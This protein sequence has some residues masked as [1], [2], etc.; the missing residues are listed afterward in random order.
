MK[1][2]WK[3][4]FKTVFAACIRNDVTPV[5][6]TRGATVDVAVKLA[7]QSEKSFRVLQ[8]NSKKTVTTVQ[9]GVLKRRYKNPPCV[10]SI[11]FLEMSRHFTSMAIVAFLVATV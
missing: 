2:H 10:N 9:P 6:A 8:F 11:R 3:R 1:H 5:M 7:T 4:K